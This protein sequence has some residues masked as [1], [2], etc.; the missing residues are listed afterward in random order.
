QKGATWGLASLNTYGNASI[1][2]NGKKDYTYLT[3]HNGKGVNVYVMDSGVNPNEAEYNSRLRIGPNF[4]KDKTADDLSNHGTTMASIIGSNTYGVAKMV[5][6]TSV[7]V[8]DQWG[9]STHGVAVAGLQWIWADMKK[10]TFKYSN[11]L[12]NLSAVYEPGD[13]FD[14]AFLAYYAKT[15]PNSPDYWIQRNIIIAAAGNTAR[16]A[17]DYSPNRLQY[18]ISVTGHDAAKTIPTNWANTG[19]VCATY[20]APG[21]QIIAFGNNYSPVTGYGTSQASAFTAGVW[22]S[23]LSD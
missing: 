15:D 10:D 16:E 4:T 12:I 13:T 1:P 5:N 8:F 9:V 14:D 19:N 17:C 20:A 3:R 22:A 6:I 7:K 11:C 2:A 21:H 18:T 23:L